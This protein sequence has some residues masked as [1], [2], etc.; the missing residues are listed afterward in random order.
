MLNQ[1]NDSQLKENWQ[2]PAMRTEQNTDYE[3]GEVS[4]NILSLRGKNKT[5]LTENTSE[6]QKCPN[7]VLQSLEFCVRNK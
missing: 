5:C 7:V 3:K 1:K 6:E 4:S 2:V